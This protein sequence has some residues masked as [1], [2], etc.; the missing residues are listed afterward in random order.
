MAPITPCSP[1]GGA[2]NLMGYALCRRPPIIA[3]CFRI[4]ETWQCCKRI[5]ASL[6][7]RPVV[8]LL[9]GLRLASWGTLG[10]SWDISEHNKRQFE[11]HV[12]VWLNVAGFRDPILT[13]FRYLEGKKAPMGVIWHAWRLYFGVLGHPG[14]I[15]GRSWDVGEYK[16]EHTFWLSV[17]R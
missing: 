1:C 2:A 16:K 5:L 15:L 4:A 14:T 13:V 12:R 9:G 11:V 8:C 6:V 10:I 7:P 3:H 17:L